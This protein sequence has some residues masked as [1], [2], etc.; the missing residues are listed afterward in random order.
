MEYEIKKVQVHILDIFKEIARVCKIL[1][2]DYF[3]MGGT[4]L[5]AYRHGGFIPWDDDLD[6]GMLREDYEFFLENAGKYLRED[7]FLQTYKTE[8]HSPFYFAKVRKANTTFVEKYCRKLDINSGI[9]VDIFP[10][11]NIPDDAKKRKKYY[12]KC[13]LLLNYYIAKEVN[14]TSVP[15][16]GIKKIIYYGIRHGLHFVTRFIPKKRLFEK[17]D[18]HMQKYNGIETEYV[19]YGGLP[20]I[21]LKKKTVIKPDTILF[22][23]IQVNCPKDL[24]QYLTDN[25]GDYMALP[26]EEERVGHAPYKVRV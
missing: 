8:P 2:I 15:Y 24:E 23:N 26:P 25:Y 13:K 17:L 3:V 5:G 16:T 18:N 1:E 6:I 21:Q 19:G 22:E 9:Y 20:K 10:Y 7:L 14:E 12:F 11:D 4:A